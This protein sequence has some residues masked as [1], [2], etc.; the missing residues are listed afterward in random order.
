MEA[1]YSGG[2]GSGKVTVIG[3]IGGGATAEE[4]DSGQGFVVVIVLKKVD[5][6]YLVSRIEEVSIGSRAV[7]GSEVVLNIGMS[8]IGK[9]AG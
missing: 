5:V 6:M 2:F 7:S 4:E 9:T 8:L 1:G 3:T